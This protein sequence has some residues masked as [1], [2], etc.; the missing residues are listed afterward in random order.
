MKKQYVAA[1]AVLCAAAVGA[2]TPSGLQAGSHET[3]VIAE[4]IKAMK[5][6]GEATGALRDML[7]GTKPFSGEEIEAIGIAIAETGGE[8]LVALFP[9]GSLSAESEALPAIWEDFETFTT[10]ANDLESSAM[11]LSSSVDGIEDEAAA[12]EAFTAAFRAMGEVCTACH[13]KFRVE[14]EQ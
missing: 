1:A 4:R 13:T 14:Q 12:K 9:E 8:S 7:I 5:S 10:Y 11:T 2:L 6:N 3:D